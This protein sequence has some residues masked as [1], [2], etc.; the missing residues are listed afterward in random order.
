MKKAPW[1]IAGWLGITLIAGSASWGLGKTDALLNDLSSTDTK[2]REKAHAALVVVG[3]NVLDAALQRMRTENRTTVVWAK[4]TAD[5]IVYNASAP[6]KEKE[7]RNVERI[8]LN[9]LEGDSN[10]T[11]QDTALRLLSLIGSQESVPALADWMRVRT[12]RER[13]RRALERI[14]GSQATDAFV[15]AL[16]KTREARWKADL[17]RTLGARGDLR[18][19]SAVVQAFD[20]PDP[21]VRL[22]AIAAAGRLPHAQTRR[23]LWKVWERNATEEER[24]TATDSLLRIAESDFK[25]GK[26]RSAE[27]IYR[28]LSQ[29]A[30]SS[31][32]RKA[33]SVGLERVEGAR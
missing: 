33:G 3:P 24:T 7:R 9:F 10:R 20:V 18:A 6:G 2:T 8:L 23:A 25:R 12:M 5:R 32:I 11:Q 30:G 21:S 13:I 31:L 28:R 19:K 4:R 17:L 1:A 16:S 22:A 26:S 29:E 15:D 14:P 27:V